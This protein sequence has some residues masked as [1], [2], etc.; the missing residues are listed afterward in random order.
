MAKSIAHGFVNRAAHT[1]RQSRRH[2]PGLF[3]HMGAI[4]ARKCQTRPRHIMP[5]RNIVAA[6][7]A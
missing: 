1:S 3:R 4:M 2:R 5:Q 7:N 6:L